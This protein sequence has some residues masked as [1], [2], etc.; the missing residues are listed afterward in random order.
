MTGVQTC[1]LPIYVSDNELDIIKKRKCVIALNVSSNMNNSVGLPDYKRF[2]EKG[3]PVIIGNDGISSSITTELLTLLYTMHLIDESPLGFGLGDIY[4]IINNTYDYANRT[5]GTKLGRI[6]VGY[7]ADLLT[8]PYVAPTTLNSDNALGHLFFGM[9][10]SFKPNNV[11]CKGEQVVSNYKV[12][13]ELF[14]KY[15]E[16]KKYADKLWEN[17]QKEDA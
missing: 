13:D 6:E 12:K 4:E 9:F 14:D 5:L 10:N 11:F 2:R 8:V 16:A 1:A 15:R 17:I 3:I 7:D